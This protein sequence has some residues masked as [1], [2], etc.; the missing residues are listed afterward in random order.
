M[1]H[2]Y[3]AYIVFSEQLNQLFPNISRKSASSE[4]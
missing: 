4:A 3:E 1:Q 2:K